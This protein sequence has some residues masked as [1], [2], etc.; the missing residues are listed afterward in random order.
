MK[1]GEKIRLLRKKAGISQAELAKMINTTKQNMYKYET[2][3]ISNIPT[4]K[5]PLISKILN[6]TP[7]YLMGWDE[8]LMDSEDVKKIASEI[9][10][11][12]D[13][14]NFFANVIQMSEE[15]F[16][17]ARTVIEA[18]INKDKS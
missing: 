10:K 16:S 2:G 11:Q 5:I 18:L 17:T 4:Q 1:T 8:E 12:E 7:A 3:L 6:T 9:Q 13:L 14:K 15:D